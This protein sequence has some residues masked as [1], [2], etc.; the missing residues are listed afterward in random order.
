[1]QSFFDK[2]QSSL[3]SDSRPRILLL[4]DATK[5]D[6]KVL[7]SCVKVYSARVHNAYTWNLQFYPLIE[8]KLYYCETTANVADITCY[9]KFYLRHT[10]FIITEMSSGIP[11]R[12]QT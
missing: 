8:K 4:I 6:E 7:S 2:V 11:I 10:N 12:K 5:N 1:M 3:Y 9:L